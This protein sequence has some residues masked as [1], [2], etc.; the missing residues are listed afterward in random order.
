METKATALKTWV[1]VLVNMVSVTWKLNTIAEWATTKVI[2]FSEDIMG[3][4]A[5]TLKK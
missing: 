1:Q 2:C 3:T 4:K 5:T